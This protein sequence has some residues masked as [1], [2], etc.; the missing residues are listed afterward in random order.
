[1]PASGGR[2]R[3]SSGLSTPLAVTLAPRIAST[4]RVAP[5]R[6]T[7]TLV[8]STAAMLN[9][10]RLWFADLVKRFNVGS[11]QER[12]NADTLAWTARSDRSTNFATRRNHSVT[13]STVR[14]TQRLR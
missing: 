2:R 6:V 9:Q 13:G 3:G 8:A 7:P 5:R 11:T 10:S 4:P 14:A 12:G 1:M